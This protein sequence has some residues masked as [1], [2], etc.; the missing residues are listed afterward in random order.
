MRTASFLQWLRPLVGG[1]ETDSVWQSDKDTSYAVSVA[2]ILHFSARSGLKSPYHTGATAPEEPHVYLVHQ[3]GEAITQADGN[4]FEKPG[5]VQLPGGKYDSSRGDTDR[6]S[7]AIR[8]FREETGR[9]L[10][11]E[12][13][14]YA[15][16]A[17]LPRRSNRPGSAFHQHTSYL[18]ICDAP[19]PLEKGKKPDHDIVRHGWVP[20][21]KV[22]MT[23]S[24]PVTWNVPMARRHW[25][26]TCRL[27]D[28]TALWRIRSVEERKHASNGN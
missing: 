12:Q 26:V 24:Q 21:K 22:V 20:L 1:G 2:C 23:R 14:V 8:E 10:T 28:P 17:P 3:K 25:Y 5:A 9:I 11:R 6:I 15:P 13:F 27:A 7:T 16:Y 18:V 4:I 19:P